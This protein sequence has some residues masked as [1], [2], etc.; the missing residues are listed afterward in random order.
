MDLPSGLVYIENFV[1]SEYQ[2]ELI[3]FIDNQPW[4]TSISRR[5]Q[6]YGYRYNYKDKHAETKLG[7]IPKVFHKLICDLKD[8]FGTE[9]NQVIIN[10]YHPKQGIAA[11]IDH[12]KY[13]GPVVASVSLLSPVEMEFNIGKEKSNI[14]LEP[15]SVVI[16]KDEARYKWTH[17]IRSR[18]YDHIRGVAIRRKRRVSVTFRTMNL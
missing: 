15:K 6:H 1:S 3:K 7:E 9:P 17:Q 11:H 5:T 14:L 2:N 12:V 4:D 13:F 18:E 16:L 8:A 10:E